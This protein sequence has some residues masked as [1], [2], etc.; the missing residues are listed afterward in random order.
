MC[1]MWV[2]GCLT[3]LLAGPD[4]NRAVSRGTGI[5]ANWAKLVLQ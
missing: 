3:A 1:S 2:W 4:P 5:V